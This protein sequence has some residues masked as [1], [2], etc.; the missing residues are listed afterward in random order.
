MTI[1]AG[2][3]DIIP[4]TYN[5]DKIPYKIVTQRI[6]RIRI[7]YKLQVFYCKHTPETVYGIGELIEQRIPHV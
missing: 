3:F 6:R 4:G 7:F 5:Q 2:R 1:S